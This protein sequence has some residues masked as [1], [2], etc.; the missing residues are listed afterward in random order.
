MSFDN[1]NNENLTKP[2]YFIAGYQ[3]RPVPPPKTGP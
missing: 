1:N 2:L 3:Y